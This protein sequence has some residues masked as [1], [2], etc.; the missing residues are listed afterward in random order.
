MTERIRHFERNRQGRDLAVGDIH[1]HP[2]RLQVELERIGFDPVRD[3]LFS[4]GDL[5][6]RGPDSAAA[7]ALLEQ[8][9]FHAVRGNHDLSVIA[10]FAPDADEDVAAGPPWAYICEG[11]EWAAELEPGE[12]EALLDRL[13]ALPYVVTVETA[14]GTVDIVHAEVP[15]RFERWAA[16]CTAVATERPGGPTCFAACWDR[17]LAYYAQP[18]AGANTT[19]CVL[20]DLAQAIHGHTPMVDQRQGVFIG[21]LGNRYWIDTGGWLDGDRGR[22]WPSP[23]RLTL[24]DLAS[25]GEAL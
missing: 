2:G 13:V 25:P 18:V 17:D 5:V 8:P 19:A 16:F 22:R 3:R 9:W 21:R 20:P 14:V 24:V 15:R 11:H 4:V 23:P 10:R 12:C 1:G 7:V 6:D